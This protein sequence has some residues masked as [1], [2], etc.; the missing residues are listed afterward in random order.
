MTLYLPYVDV[1]KD[2]V[3]QAGS[4]CEFLQLDKQK[5]QHI[6]LR[7]DQLHFV[8]FPQKSHS[9]FLSC[10]E[11]LHYYRDT[12]ST[13]LQPNNV[14]WVC[15][16]MCDFK[17][18]DIKP[19]M[20]HCSGLLGLTKE[21]KNYDKMQDCSSGTKKWTKLVSHSLANVRLFLLFH[22]RSFRP[23]SLTIWL[24]FLRI[25]YRWHN[26]FTRH[27]VQFRFQFIDGSF[28]GWFSQYNCININFNI[29]VC[30]Y[31][32]RSR[33]FSLCWH[34][35]FPFSRRFSFGWWFSFR[36]L[37]F[38]VR[39]WFSDDLTVVR[40]RILKCFTFILAPTIIISKCIS[41]EGVVVVL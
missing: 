37:V 40:L 6:M 19:Q 8:T 33:C 32:F 11:K 29:F 12:L 14:T 22:L 34:F 2:M 10:N 5:H 39:N 18:L 9:K 16:S 3:F 35:T 13:T 24:I 1:S 15:T 41:K 21:K 28:C 38:C 7:W 27:R 17:D 36:C 25:W 4:Q 23:I 31:I 30:F 26:N 20:S